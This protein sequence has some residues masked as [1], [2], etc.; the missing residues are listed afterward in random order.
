MCFGFPLKGMFLSVT[1]QVGGI[2]DFL[3]GLGV[4]ELVFRDQLS[5]GD[6]S[7]SFTLAYESL[8]MCENIRTV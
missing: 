2:A 6:L 1:F 3:L 8:K 7:L 5:C 4:S